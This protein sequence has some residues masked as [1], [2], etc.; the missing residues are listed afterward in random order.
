[1]NTSPELVFL[2]LLRAAISKDACASIPAT[3]QWNEVFHL[4]EQHQVLPLIVEAAWRYAPDEIPEEILKRYKARSRRLVMT[5]AVK[6]DRFLKLY[7]FLAERGLTPIVVKGIVCRSLYPEP[8]FRLSADEDLLIEP[9]KAEEYHRALLDHGMHL[10]KPASDPMNDPETGYLSQD[11]VLYI[12]VHRYLF[13][14]GSEAYGEY[15][16]FFKDVYSRSETIDINDV[17]IRVPEATDHLFYL[18]I[19][20]LKHFLHGGFGIRQICDIGLFAQAYDSKIDWSRFCEQCRESN[21]LSFAAAVFG[22]AEQQLG[23]HCILPA[24]LAV[25]ET[26]CEALLQDVMDSGVFGSSTLSRKHSSSITLGAVENAKKGASSTRGSLVRTLFPP[27]SSLTNRYTYLN[28]HPYLLPAVWA[29]RLVRYAK[30]RRTEN[31]SAAEAL[32]IGKERSMLLRELGL[33]EPAPKKTVDTGIYISSLM[34]LIQAGEEVGLPV[35]GSS[36][37]PFLGDGRD[38]V[39]LRGPDRPLKR[40][41]VVLYRRNNGDYVLHRIHRVRKIGDGV[42]YDMIGDAQSQIEPGIRRDKV[43]AVANRAKRKGKIIEPGNPYWW[44]FQNVWIGMIPLRRP[45]LELYTACRR[46]IFISK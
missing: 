9:E 17:S 38:Q 44:F 16:R 11:G 33:L 2:S 32:R 18:V 31:D 43:F 46:N 15:N 45:V 19:H 1:M 8:D 24:D 3:D 13:P 25:H 42:V 29:Q 6:T 39:F 10:Q 40:G 20:A 26:D 7:A 21:A 14:P 5:Q 34:E 12:E 37:T 36:M 30:S 4:A 22:V 28:K 35:A 23:I 41:D 27:A